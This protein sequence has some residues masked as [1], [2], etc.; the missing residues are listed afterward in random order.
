MK[1]ISTKKNTITK[2]VDNKS[3]LIAKT[4]L[5]DGTIVI[6]TMEGAVYA[7]YDLNSNLVGSIRLVKAANA[8]TT[9][10]RTAPATSSAT[11]KR[12]GQ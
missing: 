9:Q 12:V 4:E 7:I 5:R 3:I 6:T 11:T 8:T 10:P 2:T 1:T